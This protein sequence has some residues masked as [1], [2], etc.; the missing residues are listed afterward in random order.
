MNELYALMTTV[1]DLAQESS[2]LTNYLNS[3]WD[4]EMVGKEQALGKLICE[5]IIHI[6][7]SELFYTSEELILEPCYMEEANKI[8]KRKLT[9]FRS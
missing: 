9:F 3:K 5:H 8:D 1:K 4:R 7:I 6:T 2:F